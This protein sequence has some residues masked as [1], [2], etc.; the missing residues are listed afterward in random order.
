[1]A[2]FDLERDHVGDGWQPLIE[3]L[4]I[5][6]LNIDP[7]YEVLQIKE[8]FGGLRYYIQMSFEMSI[9]NAQ[10]ALI[11]EAEA[12]SFTICEYCGEPGKERRNGLRWI[13]TTCEKHCPYPPRP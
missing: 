8:K 10:E 7:N 3:K 1:M 12:K 2:D 11:E 9:Y 6:L 5:D 13:K 4:H